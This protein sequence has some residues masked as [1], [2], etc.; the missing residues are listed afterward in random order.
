MLGAMAVRAGLF[1]R[2]IIL[3]IFVTIGAGRLGMIIFE[4]IPRAGIVLIGKTG[5]ASMTLQAI[6]SDTSQVGGK[7]W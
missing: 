7:T 4:K 1:G 2:R 6:S 3:I 5:A